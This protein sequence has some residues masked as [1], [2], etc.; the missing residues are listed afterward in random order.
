MG[1]ILSC[2]TTPQRIGKLIHIIPHLSGYKYFVINVCQEYK[3]FGKFKI[4]KELLQLCKKNKKVVFQFVDDYGPVCKYV[5]GFRFMKKKKLLNDKLII[6]DDDTKYNKN[7]FYELM[8]S[9]TNS[10]ITTG[11]GF[12]YDEKFNYKIVEGKTDMVEGYGGIC[13]DYDQYNEFIEWFVGFYKHFKFKN[14]ILI[15]KYLSASFLGDD[16]ILSNLYNH[17]HA[18]QSGRQYIQP[19]SY[20][21]E[22]DALHKNN[23]F[24]SNMGS[25]KFLNDEIMIFN[26]FKL[27]YILNKSINEIRTISKAT[28]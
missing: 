10:N 19:Y 12:D 9:K 3:R 24:G 25:Y 14:D 22:D 27:K 15:D 2:A 18:I 16:F 11:S 17:K 28:A 8:H 26:T 5:G 1:F 20:G 21:F 7:L 13:F 4:P 6:I 23:V